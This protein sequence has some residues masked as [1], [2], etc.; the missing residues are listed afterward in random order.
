M[1]RA[2]HD[3]TRFAML[4]LLA[5]LCA[6]ASAPSAQPA[7]ATITPT[8]PPERPPAQLD[9]RALG[10]GGTFADLVGAA[11]VLLRDGRGDSNAGCLLDRDGAG[12]KLK[13]DLMPAL[14]ELP[15]VPV[16]LDA[17]LQRTRGP[18][19]VLTAWG[20]AGHGEPELALTSFTALPA[21]YAR[22]PVV[23]LV[24]TDA[25]M[26]VRFGNTQVSD[27]GPELPSNEAVSRVIDSPMLSMPGNENATFYV[28]AEAGVSLE[29]V[30][31]LLS[32]LPADKAVALAIVLPAGTKL[33]AAPPPPAPSADACPDGL[34]ELDANE[35]QGDLERSAIV[36]ALAPL[37]DAA[38]ECMR[39]A[40][41]TAR[42][43]GKLV[44]ALRIAGDGS[45]PRACTV[46]DAIGDPALAT[47]VL[48]G[49]RRLRFPAP[50]PPGSVDVQLPLSLSP[51]GPQ[52]Q[53][54]FCPGAVIKT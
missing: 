16:D 12:F 30:A 8:P 22:G 37:Q 34:P 25:G 29:R 46:R 31:Q 51:V 2:M 13:A 35:A 14:D 9:L 41:G 38:S 1:L 54:A 42:A 47:C 39:N 10:N 17:Q 40:T 5:C 49:A 11:R 18:A 44:L 50:N 4:G 33:P 26:Y 15:D 48:S 3:P 52:R 21:E 6:C 32:V 19:R 36:A 53:Q 7:A 27:A 20:P 28:S 45:V 43:G 24:L 23:V